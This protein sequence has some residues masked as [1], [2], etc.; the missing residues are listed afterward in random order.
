M[1]EIAKCPFAAGHGA[2]TKVSQQSN[3]DWW[4]N[5]LNLKILGLH[6]EKVNPLGADFDYAEAFKKLD[7][8][9]VKKDIFALMTVSQ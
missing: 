4:P 2:R 7:L 5:R 1:N 6:S 9:A 8:A 3:Q